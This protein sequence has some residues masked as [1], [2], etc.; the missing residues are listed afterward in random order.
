MMTDATPLPAPQEA[1]RDW[2]AMIAD[3]ERSD[4]P[5]RPTWRETAT[6]AIAGVLLWCSAALLIIAWAWGGG[7]SWFACAG[8]AFTEAMLIWFAQRRSGAAGRVRAR[9]R[10]MLIVAAYIGVLTLL[11][12][13]F[14]QLG[15]GILFMPIPLLF[16]SACV[17]VACLSRVRTQRADAIAGL[18]LLIFTVLAC[19]SVVR[20]RF[21]LLRAAGLQVRIAILAQTYENEVQHVQRHIAT[22]THQSSKDIIAWRV[23]PAILHTYGIA[24]APHGL[25]YTAYDVSGRELIFFRSDLCEHIDGQWFWCRIN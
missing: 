25:G 5:S 8:I 12:L 24:Y 7:A 17:L 3:A 10:A 13:D 6:F 1:P 14:H 11:I 23:A 16:A 9:W 19:A 21:E 22:H 18:T 20:F 2:E 15:L 4:I